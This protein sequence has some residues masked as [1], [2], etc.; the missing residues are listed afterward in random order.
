MKDSPVLL[1]Y[2]K[3]TCPYCKKVLDFISDK[4]L[5]VPLKNIKEDPSARDELLHLGE[6]IQVPCLFIDGKAMYESDEIIQWLQSEYI[7]S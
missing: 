3:P 2:Y 1:L 5:S 4:N 7:G 6:K